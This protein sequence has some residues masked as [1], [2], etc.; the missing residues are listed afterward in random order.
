MMNPK[1]L[2]NVEVPGYIFFSNFGTFD[3]ETKQN[4]T[5]EQLKEY[6][7]NKYQFEDVVILQDVALA[8][9][10]SAFIPEKYSEWHKAW[11]NSLVTRLALID[12][13]IDEMG[14]E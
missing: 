7:I 5:E 2:P 14:D 9:K 3:Y 8:S 4:R 13:F 6:L 11:Y 10:F 1:Y 12:K